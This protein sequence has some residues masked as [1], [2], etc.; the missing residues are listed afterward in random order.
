MHSV[1]IPYTLSI[2]CAGPLGG[3][4]TVIFL[5]LARTKFTP[6]TLSS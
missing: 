3:S 2:K 5:E 6:R 1:G 4:D